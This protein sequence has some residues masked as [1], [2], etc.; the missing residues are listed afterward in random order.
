LEVNSAVYGVN[1]TRTCRTDETPSPIPKPVLKTQKAE[2]E[3]K[4]EINAYLIP[5]ERYWILKTST[6]LVLVFVRV[7]GDQS[8]ITW[9][10]LQGGGESQKY[11][12]NNNEES[13]A[14]RGF[15]S[16]EVF[17]KVR[18]VI[19]IKASCYVETIPEGLYVKTIPEVT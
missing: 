17:L 5:G 6:S 1:R 16:L 4:H 11:F 3:A 12:L 10:N 8:K 14:G 7:F 15:S 18:R 9:V 2:N 19:Q 13:L